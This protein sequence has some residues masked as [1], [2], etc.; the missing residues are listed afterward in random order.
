MRRITSILM[1]LACATLLFVRP[2]EAWRFGDDTLVTID[3][4]RYTSEDFKRW[5]KFWNDTNLPLPKTLDPFVE[6]LLLVREGE[7]MEL[8]WEPAF[9]RQTKVFL[10]SRA[11]LMLKH[12][13]VDSRI[14]ITDDDL[15]AHY[16]KHY[17]PRWLV[18]RL[19]FNDEE[20]AAAAWRQLKEGSLTI[21]ELLARDT[22]A[23]GPASLHENS[24]R[25]NEIDPGWVAILQKLGAGD[26]VDP[27]EHSGGILLYHLKDVIAGDAE[28][29]VMRRE[30]IRREVW[31]EQENVLTTELLSRLREKYEV[32]VDEERLAAI[33]LNASAE[34][35]TD[36]VIISTNREN[37]SEKDFMDIARR[38]MAQRP[39]A[40]H[41]V[42]DEEVVKE[43][44]GRVVSGIIA[45]SL[46]NWESLARH[47]EKE[48]PFKWEFDFHMRHRLTTAVE[49]RLFASADAIS[50]AEIRKHYEENLSRFTQPALAKM[51][52]IDDTQGPVDQIWADVL[53]NKNFIKAISEH[54][55]RHVPGQE[56]PV[57][58]LDPN[59]KAVVDRLAVGET[60][61]P[62]VAQGSRLI[63]H[64]IDRTPEEPL[65][66]ERVSGAIRSRMTQEKMEQQRTA[67]LDLVKSRSKIEVKGRKWQTLRKE[68]GGGR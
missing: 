12:D 26:V 58:H 44:K 65:P 7:R 2:A 37:I 15:K 45:Q 19:H 46:T 9:Q 29:L 5:W 36:A 23:G 8:A 68:L 40:A 41:V 27:D 22:G 60:S 13:E 34:S 16:E 20:A 3:G 52:I 25:P 50:D 4:T 38:D 53:G 31:K 42:F 51:Y 64:L 1:L 39:T 18:Q 54:L 61:P 32:E 14:K 28:D 67:Y 30:Q 56:V 33:D 66:L 62:F 35:L 63:V 48:E 21:E 49:N 43:I 11:L 10:T 24:L 17:S 59:V 55:G 6:W 57:N 47:Y